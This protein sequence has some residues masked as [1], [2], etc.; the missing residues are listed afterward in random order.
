MH[1]FRLFQAFSIHF[2]LLPD[3]QVLPPHSLQL[4][5]LPAPATPG[6]ATPST[7]ARG[8][9]AQT[10]EVWR[11]LRA[12]Q[13]QQQQQVGM[14]WGAYGAAKLGCELGKLGNLE[15]GNGALQEVWH[16]KWVWAR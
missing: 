10:A 5:S 4:V 6:R 16:S 3:G 7:A 8:A 2:Q 13:G 11:G 9:G 1:F 15:H 12:L 14:D